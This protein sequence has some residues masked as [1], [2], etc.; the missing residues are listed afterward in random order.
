MNIELRKFKEEDKEDFID[1]ILDKMD[2]PLHVYD[3]PFPIDRKSLEE[4]FAFFLNS[5]EFYAVD[6]QKK[7]I[8]YV[9]LN[10]TENENVRNLG[11]CLHTKY[12]GKG[13][14]TKAVEKAIHMAKEELKAKK[15]LAGTADSNTPAVKVLKHFGFIKIDSAI[16]AFC[17]D[18]DDK[19]ISFSG[20]SYVLHLRDF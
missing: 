2:S 5:D 12:Q 8:G 10:K 3:H 9:A 7:C 19:P 15:L 11:F 14:G 1:L 17:R 20:S 16:C 18:A 6:F 4:I 13:L